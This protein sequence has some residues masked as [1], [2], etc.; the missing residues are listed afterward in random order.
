MKKF[1]FFSQTNPNRGLRA[2]LSNEQ[3]ELST[4]FLPDQIKDGMFTKSVMKRLASAHHGTTII[5][6]THKHRIVLGIKVVNIEESKNNKKA[7][8]LLKN[9]MS[10]LLKNKDVIRYFEVKKKIDHFIAN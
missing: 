9:E 6:R 10:E 8:K 1:K 4:I 3:K 5:L 2:Y 7:L